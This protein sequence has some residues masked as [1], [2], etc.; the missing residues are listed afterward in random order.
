MTDDYL[1]HAL[2]LHID[3]LTVRSA[4]LVLRGDQGTSATGSST[5]IRV[6]DHLLL[7]TAGHVIKD[8]TG[9]QITLA[10]PGRWSGGSP[11]RFSSRSCHPERPPPSTDV[12]WI[13]LEAA[14]ASTTGLKFIELSDLLPYQAFDRTRPFIV[15]GYPFE[16]A[17]ITTA[18][19]DVE[20]TAAGTMM[21]KSEELPR[22][23]RPDELALEWPPRRKDGQ[24]MGRVPHP[25]G[26]SGGGTW[27]QPRHDEHL[28]MSP[29][30]LRFV[31][32]NL[33]W[34]GSQGILFATRV[35]NWLALVARDFPD[36]RELIAAVRPSLTPEE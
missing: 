3:Y 36:T 18:G 21:V 1:D 6:G 28:I 8:V 15:H 4:A 5:C 32:I 9:A 24:P 12:A 19:A 14:T 31:G 13:E 22:Q 35:E 2:G 25:G 10:P 11:L 16:S 23:L 7:A 30:R 20:S 29:T 17:R 26:V 34:L 27:R 33:R